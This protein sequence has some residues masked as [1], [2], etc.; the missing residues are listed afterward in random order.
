V[1][2]ILLRRDRVLAVVVVVHHRALPLR[3]TTVWAEGSGQRPPREG[4]PR[5]NAGRVAWSKRRWRPLSLKVGAILRGAWF[6][7]GLDC[8][9][10]AIARFRARQLSDSS[11]PLP[12]TRCL[13]LR[14]PLLSEAP[15]VCVFTSTV[16]Q[17]AM[18][19]SLGLAHGL[20]TTRAL[21]P[22]A[23]RPA[24]ARSSLRVRA[25]GPK[26]VREYR[27]GDDSVSVNRGSAPAGD[28]QGDPKALYADELPEVRSAARPR[29]Q[30]TRLSRA[31]PSRAAHIVDVWPRRPAASRTLPPRCRPGAASR[32]R[33]PCPPCHLPCAASPQGA[34]QGNAGPA[35][36]G[37][38]WLGWLRQQG[39]HKRGGGGGPTGCA[40]KWSEGMMAAH[41]LPRF[42]ATG[43]SLPRL[44]LY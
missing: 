36:E 12:A 4:P 37:V 20:A 2:L 30:Q 38:C 34:F 6:R 41:A 23:R 14:A 35:P 19:S 3:A 27:E 29:S 8:G 17:P 28:A 1:P 7:G 39:V 18:A 10:I 40:G 25:E 16:A 24:G 32:R 21:R 43:G 26:V 22:E 31:H 5:K 42:V 44:A 15:L 13:S 9:G 33:P 11:P